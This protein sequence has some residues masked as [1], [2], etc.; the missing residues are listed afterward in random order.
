MEVEAK[1]KVVK[2]M[3]A[4]NPRTFHFPKKI[5]SSVRG[6][7]TLYYSAD[8]GVVVVVNEAGKDILEASRDGGTTEQIARKLV[9]DQESLV[10][11]VQNLIRPF[12]LEMVQYRFL[13]TAKPQNTKEDHSVSESV[14]IQLTDLYLHVTDACN[15]HCIYCYN[16]SQRSHL[17]KWARGKSSSYL[18]NQQIRHLLDEAAKLEVK[19]AVFTGGEPICRRDLCKLAAYAKEQGLSTT[20]LTNGT[21]IDRRTASHISKSF[22]S[23]VVSLDSWIKEEYELLKPGAPFEK[24][25]Q[26]VRNLV[27]AEVS[28]LFIRPVITRLNLTSLPQFPIFASN[29]LGCLQFSPTLYLP[30][31]PGEL[32][33]LGLLPDPETYWIA[34][35]HFHGE[36]KKLG[37][38]SGQ[39]CIP[40]EASGSCGAGGGV[41]SV[42]TNGDVYPCQCLHYDEFRAGN[43]KDNSISEII[44]RSPVLTAFRKERWPWFGQCSEC[45]LMRLCSST[46]RVFYKAFKEHEEMFFARL[47]PFFKKEI[48]IKLWQEVKKRLRETGQTSGR[49]FSQQI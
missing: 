13:Q 25:L 2:V 38:I 47:C 32:E 26:G 40:L 23:V 18:T 42:A 48:E 10:P 15:L 22:D 45:A 3:N 19:E 28:S 41:L 8:R 43:V 33:A 37:G 14:P 12:L 35:E 20:L 30:N 46:C 7:E 39:E 36:L 17:S 5:Y 31:H 6:S 44:A 49:V 9:S 1:L 21:L 27:E 24:A 29:H 34:L 4:D 11:M 16:A